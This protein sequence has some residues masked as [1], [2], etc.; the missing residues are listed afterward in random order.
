MIIIDNYRECLILFQSTIKFYTMKENDKDKLISLLSKT[1]GETLSMQIEKKK[2]KQIIVETKSEKAFEQA[3]KTLVKLS[4]IREDDLWAV[5]NRIEDKDKKVFMPIGEEYQSFWGGGPDM[6]QAICT[7][8]I[9]RCFSFGDNT[10][11]ITIC[12]SYECEG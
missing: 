9:R 7:T 11:C 6:Y 2:G 1:L 3:R 5:I 12:F 4:P 10:L 8:C